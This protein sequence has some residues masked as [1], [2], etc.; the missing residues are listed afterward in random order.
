[1]I[2][3]SATSLELLR[4]DGNTVGGPCWREASCVSAVLVVLLRVVK[5]PIMMRITLHRAPPCNHTADILEWRVENVDCFF[6]VSPGRR[7]DN[8][9][10]NDATMLRL[11]VFCHD[12]QEI[13]D[14]IAL[15]QIEI[16]KE[17]STL[18]KERKRMGA[19][20]ENVI[21]LTALT[22]LVGCR[23]ISSCKRKKL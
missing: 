3:T 1:M 21:L 9:Y 7:R 10:G 5:N 17:V 19:S 2:G 14:Y 16:K 20:V 11:F 22:R 23:M 18:M 13:E 15:R 6:S 8:T 4:F 12:R